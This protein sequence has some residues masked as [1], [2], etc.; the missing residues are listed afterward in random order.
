MKVSVGAVGSSLEMH[1]GCIL[2]KDLKDML[3]IGNGM[4]EK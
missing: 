4:L 3:M 2:T 1:F